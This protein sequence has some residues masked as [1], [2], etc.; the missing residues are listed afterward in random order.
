MCDDVRD[1]G[2]SCAIR[3]LDRQPLAVA[4]ARAALDKIRFIIILGKDN[5]TYKTVSFKIVSKDGTISVFHAIIH[6][7]PS[8]SPSPS[9]LLCR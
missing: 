5:E 6:C 3:Y 4:L 7:G 1:A 8:P 2:F 9:L